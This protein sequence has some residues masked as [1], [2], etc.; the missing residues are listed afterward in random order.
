MSAACYMARSG[1]QVTILEK[2]STMGG[3]IQHRYRDGFKFNLGPTMYLMPEIFEEFFK[4]FGINIDDKLKFQEVH[5]YFRVFGSDDVYDLSDVS[6]TKSLLEQNQK[7]S[8]RQFKKMMNRSRQQYA[9]LRLHYSNSRWSGPLGLDSVSEIINVKAIKF[10]GKFD[11]FINKYIANH[12]VKSFY[13]YVAGMFDDRRDKLSGIMHVLPYVLMGQQLNS[14]KGGMDK[15]TASLTELAQS[16]GVY[17]SLN[18][19]VVKIESKFK[20]VT[21]VKLK[22]GS[23]IDCDAVI[24][25]IDYA[26]AETKMLDPGD[27]SYSMNYWSNKHYGP[28][29]LIIAVALNQKLSKLKAHNLFVSDHSEARS[30]YLHASSRLDLSDA[31]KGCDNLVIQV[32]LDEGE[33]EDINRLNLIKKSIYDRISDKC[34]EDINKFIVFDEMRAESYFEDT[35]YATRGSCYGISPRLK[36]IGPFAPRIKSKVVEGLFY[37][38]QDTVAGSGM[39][40]ALNSG[41]ISAYSLLGK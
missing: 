29:I 2:N 3:R 26:H 33:G 35:F 17:I 1:W 32:K 9:S 23:K 36:Q 38:G 34:G 18:S 41:K 22:N 25:G 20:Q 15:L 16:L 10:G 6:N 14:L 13:N 12:N 8:G 7:G 11:D 19:E 28:S 27:M 24:A 30:F 37:T 21:G 4:D 5:P 39:A 31:P 40:L